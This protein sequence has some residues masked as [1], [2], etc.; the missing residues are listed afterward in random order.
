MVP[1]RVLFGIVRA[2]DAVVVEVDLRY[3][4]KPVR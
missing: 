2:R 1:P 3:K 4:D